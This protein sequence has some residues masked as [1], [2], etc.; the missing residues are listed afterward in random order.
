MHSNRSHCDCNLSVWELKAEFSEEENQSFYAAKK[1]CY[2]GNALFFPSQAEV[3]PMELT[4]ASQCCREMGG[5]LSQAEKL[6][7]NVS[8]NS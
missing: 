1:V 5:A 4:G 8:R 6:Q 3:N 2:G 7:A